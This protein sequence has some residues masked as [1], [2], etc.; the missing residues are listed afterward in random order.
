[1]YILLQILASVLLPSSDPL[2][3]LGSFH[4]QKARPVFLEVLV[5]A[6]V[7]PGGEGGVGHHALAGRRLVAKENFNMGETP[8]HESRESSGLG[9]KGGPS[10]LTIS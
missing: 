3:V 1:M 9:D 6:A 5:S 10:Q 8:A 4:L 2:L 7:Y